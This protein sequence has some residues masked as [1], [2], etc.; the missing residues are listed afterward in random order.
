MPCRMMSE[1]RRQQQQ[2]IEIVS[3]T[4]IL[5]NKMFSMIVK[6]IT[7]RDIKLMFSEMKWRVSTVI[8]YIGTCNAKK[9]EQLEWSNAVCLVHITFLGWGMAPD[10]YLRPSLQP[11]VCM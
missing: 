8:M 3:K 6:H 5:Y 2:Q 1:H 9:H 10:I 4:I 11:L 7:H